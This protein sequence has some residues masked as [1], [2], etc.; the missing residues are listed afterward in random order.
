MTE[1]MKDKKFEQI[2]TL[3]DRNFKDFIDEY[4]L[5]GLLSLHEEARR[6]RASEARLREFLER[7]IAER[8]H[9]SEYTGISL[10]TDI[11]YVGA[12]ELLAELKGADHD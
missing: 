3:F 10:T 6:A 5:K 12:S 7:V 1:R 8:E 2:G 9:R 4:V 11:L